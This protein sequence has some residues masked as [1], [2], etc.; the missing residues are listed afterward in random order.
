MAAG[1]A[2]TRV[3][4]R[5]TL[6]A[7]VALAA[8]VALVAS[9]IPMPPNSYVAGQFPNGEGPNVVRA[10]TFMGLGAWWDVY[11]W[12]PTFTRGAAPLRVSD[13]DRLAA[14]GVQTLYIQ[15]ATFRN[16]ATVLDVTTLRAIIARA[17]AKKVK[18]VGWYLPQ[19]LDVQVDLT[20]MVAAIRLGLDGY[21][22]DI[23]STD[24]P[25]VAARSQM[26][27]NE[28]RFLRGAF[29]NL[30]LAAV[31]VTPVVWDELNR[32]WWPSFPYKELARWCDV[33]MPMA[34][35]TYRDAGSPWRD[36]YRYVSESVTRL[37]VRTGVKW[38]PV[39]P[40][41]GLSSL[42]STADANAMHRA[43][44]DTYAIGGSLYDD[45]STPAGLWPSLRQFRRT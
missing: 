13:V 32:S 41:G 10:E 23:E 3:R 22:I 28:M 27:V 6:A 35:W 21:A 18:V 11:D 37:R 15:T 33:W 43:M 34:Y 39:H 30:P 12:S 38:L 16:P 25:N 5:R 24:N 45:V 8:A 17:R 44:A 4:R 36:P 29:P 40:V 14:A 31:P 26:L 1:T 7:L 19:F 2:P 9:C 20:R 42:M